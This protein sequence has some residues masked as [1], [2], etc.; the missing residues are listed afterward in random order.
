MAQYGLPPLNNER[1]QASAPW[2]AVIFDDHNCEYLLQQR[3]ALTDLR[4]P[5]RWLAAAYSL[6]QWQ[7]LRRYERAVCHRADAVV[8]VSEADRV[9]LARIAGGVEIDVATNGIEV[10]DYVGADLPAALPG[11]SPYTLL[12]TGKM[13]YRPN[14]DA[15]L[16]FAQEVLPLVQAGEPTVR[17]QIVGL[18]PHARLAVLRTNPAVEITGAV[19]DTRPY[20]Q[21]ATVCI[22][23]MR[24]GGGTRLKALEAMACGKAVVSTTLGIEGIPVSDGRHLLL[25]DTPEAFA[26]AVLSLLADARQG[27]TTARRLGQAARIFVQERYDWA[28]IMPIFARVYEHALARRARLGDT[29]SVTI[30]SESD[31]SLDQSLLG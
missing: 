25:A 12:F 22:I 6:V 8:A 11:Q 3:N 30:P 1:G 13:D 31:T 26:A 20:L 28:Q 2:P 7:K 19:A 29:A 27:G 16:W 18:N 4:R 23:P 5:R 21:T 15:V 24:I 17:L 10:A 9:A 14:V